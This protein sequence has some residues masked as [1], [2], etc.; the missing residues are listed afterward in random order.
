MA[1]LYT[2]TFN[3]RIDSQQFKV[4]ITGETKSQY[5]NRFLFKFHIQTSRLALH[6][7]ETTKIRM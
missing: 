4:Q 5:Q 1:E 7:Y 2:V 3:F 6:L